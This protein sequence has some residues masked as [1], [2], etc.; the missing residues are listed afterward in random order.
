MLRAIVDNLMS[1]AVD[2]TPRGGSITSR[3]DNTG[4]G[5]GIELSIT[6]TNDSLTI[7]DLPHLF[8]P[9]WRKDAARS[10]GTHSGLGLALVAL[11]AKLLGA[12]LETDLTTS[13]AFR[14][15]LG[16]R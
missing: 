1:N 10:D 15:A 13:G 2:Y 11:Y 5:N 9:F 16:L 4:D 7:S 14:V 12:R 8:E 6:N 3:L